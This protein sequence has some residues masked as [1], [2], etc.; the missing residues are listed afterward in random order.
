M[1]QRSTVH[2]VQIQLS[3]TDRQVYQ[4]LNMSV[5]RADSETPQRLVARLLAYCLCWDPDLTFTGGVGSGDE[6]D[7][8]LRE[9]GGRIKLW[10]EVGAPD[11]KRLVK[12]AR[13]CDRVLLFAYGRRPQGWQSEHLPLLQSLP[14]I[15]AIAFDDGLLE[16]LV[17]RVDRTMSWGLTVAGGTLYVA[18]GT[19]HLEGSLTE[20]CGPPL[21]PGS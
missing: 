17:R 14:N 18:V 11:P 12:A 19:D 4:D 6:P 5:A 10:I 20:I 9:P 1:A 16:E 15:T 3:D 2:R 21:V 8:W 7:V 13:H